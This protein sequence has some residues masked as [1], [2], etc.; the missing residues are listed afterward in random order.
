VSAPIKWGRWQGYL[1]GHGWEIE[2]RVSVH[3]SPCAIQMRVVAEGRSL[4]VATGREPEAV[5]RSLL[6]GVL[7]RGNG[8]VIEAL[9]AGPDVPEEAVE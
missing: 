3:P 7:S 5:L 9:L 6:M 1:E 8:E 4:V 2:E